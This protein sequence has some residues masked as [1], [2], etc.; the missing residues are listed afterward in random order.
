MV[1]QCYIQHFK[2]FCQRIWL[3]HHTSTSRKKIA[4]TIQNNSLIFQN[5]EFSFYCFKQQII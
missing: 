2:N 3:S 1:N 5:Y 4:N